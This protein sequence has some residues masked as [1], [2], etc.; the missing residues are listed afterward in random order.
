MS[1]HKYLGSNNTLGWVEMMGNDKN[2][3]F[4][5]NQWVKSSCDVKLQFA[6]RDFAIR[7]VT[8][9]GMLICLLTMLYIALSLSPAHAQYPKKEGIGGAVHLSP[10]KSNNLHRPIPI[11]VPKRAEQEP[12]LYE[13]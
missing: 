13:C 4:V 8:I 11:S 7:G 1:T 9:L 10:L 3:F 2:V 6:V 5:F 12:S